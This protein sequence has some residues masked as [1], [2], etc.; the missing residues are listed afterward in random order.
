M[1]RKLSGRAARRKGLVFERWVAEQLR[2]L[3]PNVKRHLENQMVE[4]QGY[5]LDHTGPFRIQCKKLARGAH[6]HLIHEVQCERL[7]GEIPLLVSAANGKPPLVTV[8][9]DDFLRILRDKKGLA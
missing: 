3:F 9:L 6:T 5:D 4:A 2:P 8:H 7:F 1:K